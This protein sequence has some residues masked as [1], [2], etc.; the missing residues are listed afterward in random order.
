MHG[1]ARS[2]S[3]QLRLLVAQPQKVRKAEAVDA[4]VLRVVVPAFRTGPVPQIVN[5]FGA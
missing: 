1:F 5:V 3:I 4:H 2:L